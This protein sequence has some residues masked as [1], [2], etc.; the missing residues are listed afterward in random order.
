MRPL[1]GTWEDN[2]GSKI[3]FRNPGVAN[4]APAGKVTFVNVP[5]LFSWEWGASGI[6]SG[7]GRWTITSRTSQRGGIV[8]WFGSGPWSEAGATVA[9]EVEGSISKPVLVCQYPDGD[10]ACTYTRRS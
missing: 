7:A 8:F 6:P 9:F 2:S 3:I 4:G 1:D 10:H 5:D